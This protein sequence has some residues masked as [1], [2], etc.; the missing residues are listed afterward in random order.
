MGRMPRLL[1]NNVLIKLFYFFLFGLHRHHLSS[2]FVFLYMSSIR[3]RQ[4]SIVAFV[5]LSVFLSLSSDVITSACFRMGSCLAR[6][7]SSSWSFWSAGILLWRMRSCVAVSFGSVFFAA[8][9]FLFLFL[10]IYGLH[11]FC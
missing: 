9:V 1:G 10:F 7:R 11:G 3:R 5:N 6:R 8:A 2:G 4:M